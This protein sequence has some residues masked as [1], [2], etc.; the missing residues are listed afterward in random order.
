MRPLLIAALLVPAPSLAA[1]P[2]T[3]RWLTVEKDSIVAIGACGKALCGRVER[4]LAP[5]P[6]GSPR[7][8]NNPDA[9]LRDRPIQGLAILSGFTDAGKS[10]QG[11]IY[12][13]RRG[14][15]YKS[16]LTLQPD[17]RLQVKG[18]LGPFCQSQ[19]WTRVR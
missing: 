9:K 3:G 13:P 8:V 2:V 7:D 19:Y 1:A 16:F 11:S 15:T 6:K 10:W 4:I 17:G 18:C 5:Q 12:D 14:K